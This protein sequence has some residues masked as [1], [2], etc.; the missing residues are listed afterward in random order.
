MNNVWLHSLSF[1]M[2]DALKTAAH[3]SGKMNKGELEMIDNEH[4]HTK[5]NTG[6]TC[7]KDKKISLQ[8]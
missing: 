5:N 7:H 2:A 1:L 3:F 6:A 4:M 8:S